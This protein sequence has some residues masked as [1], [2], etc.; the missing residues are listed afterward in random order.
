[1]EHACEAAVESAN[2]RL[3]KPPMI[4]PSCTFKEFIKTHSLFFQTHKRVTRH[5]VRS[6]KFEEKKAPRLH[7]SQAHVAWYRVSC[8]CFILVHSISVKFCFQQ[9]KQINRSRISKKKSIN[10]HSVSMK[11]CWLLAA[12]PLE[13][14]KIR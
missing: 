1:M 7:G 12:C 3:Y 8:H 11:T 6:Y 9:K 5:Q 14:S 4:N 2:K 13:T 10:L